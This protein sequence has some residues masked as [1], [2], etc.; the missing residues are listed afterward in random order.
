MKETLRKPPGNENKLLSNPSNFKS[1]PITKFN[2]DYKDWLRFWDQFMV[3]VDSSNISNI[4]KFNY[5]LE[6][7][8]GKP[9][10]D[11]LGLPN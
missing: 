10:D 3:E 9:R 2:G 8:E 6:L 11:I 4:S 5:L 7:V 1:I